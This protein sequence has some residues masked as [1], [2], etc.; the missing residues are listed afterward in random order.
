MN[1]FFFFLIFYLEK[2]YIYKYRRIR[3]IVF[4]C[5]NITTFTNNNLPFDSLLK[6]IEFCV[7]LI[8]PY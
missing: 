4:I 1:N 6:V 2:I 5:Y 8:K 7:I 3:K